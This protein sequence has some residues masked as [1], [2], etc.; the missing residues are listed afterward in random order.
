MG[1]GPAVKLAKD[2][3]AAY[4]TRIGIS[5][6]VVYTLIYASFIAINTIKP[7]LMEYTFGGLNVAVIYG[8]GLIVLAL[9]LATVYNHFCTAAEKRLNR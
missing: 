7:S 3:A 5:M 4:K 2:N 1:H 9:V 6:F 8:L